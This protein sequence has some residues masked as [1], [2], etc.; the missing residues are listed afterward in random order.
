MSSEGEIAHNDLLAVMKFM[1]IRNWRYGEGSDVLRVATSRLAG[2]QYT[3]APGTGKDT[4]S[5]Q[6]L[7]LGD[8]SS[9]IKVHVRVENDFDILHAKAEGLNVIR[10]EC[11]R[12]W[13]R[14]I[15]QDVTAFGGDQDGTQAVRANIVSVA[16]YAKGLLRTIPLGAA[17]ATYRFLPGSGRKKNQPQKR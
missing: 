17:G 9:V 6:P 12:L 5:T 16:E 10:Y 14:S 15:N 4:R 7:Q 11:G 1:H 13:Q 8:A 3:C 2:S